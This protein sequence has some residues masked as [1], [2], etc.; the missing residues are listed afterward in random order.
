[1]SDKYYWYADYDKSTKHYYV[2]SNYW[3][4]KHTKSII[5]LHLLIYEKYRKKGYRV[6]HINHD[7]LDNR[8]CNL[9]VIEPSNN[10]KNRRSKNA[11]NKSGYRNVFWNSTIGKWT[12]NLCKDY[13]QIHIG[14][15]ND[16]NDAG[17]AAE[18]AR[19]KYYGQYAG[20]N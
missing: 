13:K 5:R 6:D 4:D 17:R 10:S 7:G 19:K 9:R 3:K 11:N 14:D 2:L 16:V 12:V 15:Y 18:L 1:M 8:K 20:K